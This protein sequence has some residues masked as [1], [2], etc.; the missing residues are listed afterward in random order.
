[1]RYSVSDT[2]E[3]GDYMVG[4]RIINEDVRAEMKQ[5][6]YEIQNGTF[7]NQWIQENKDN[8]PQFN[9]MKAQ[10]LDHDMVTVGKELRSMMSWID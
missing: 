7:A 6:L 2:A 5:V 1:M 10:A 3:Y 8:R 4:K 9:Q